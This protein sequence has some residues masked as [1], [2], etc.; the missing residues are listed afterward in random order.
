MKQADIEPQAGVNMSVDDRNYAQG[1]RF[2][3]RRRCH[4]PPENMRK[5]RV[6]TYAR[7]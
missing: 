6:A 7:E 1:P 4:D 3:N 5:V 2:E